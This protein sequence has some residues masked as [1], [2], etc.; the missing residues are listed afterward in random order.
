M[1]KT[2]LDLDIDNYNLQDL[3]KLFRISENFT[4]TDMREA[5]RIVLQ[6]HPDKSNLD[7]KYFLF[8][9]QAYKLIYGI[10]EFRQKIKRENTDYDTLDID[11]NKDNDIILKFLQNKS[12]KKDF[13][14]LFNE[15]F[16]KTK[17][18]D[19]FSKNGYNDW[20]TS[21]EDIED[22]TKLS[23]IEQEKK[24][25]L[26]KK[27]IKTLIPF[28]NISSIENEGYELDRSKPNDYSSSVFSTLS[29]NDL[30]K[31][32]QESIIPV[33][34]EDIQNIKKKSFSQLKNERDK[35]I[36]LPSLEQANKLL[37]EQKNNII[38]ESNLRAFN[39]IK[40]DEN[41]RRVNEKNL[42]FMRQLL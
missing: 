41:I 7:K 18:D 21:N 6:A 15:I 8:F 42:H 35:K 23:K 38:K 1:K 29:Y 34:K 40:E 26:K 28:Q 24:L 22:Y 16:E 4:E 32:H 3:I 33:T 14:K 12:V 31:A 37:T 10:F 30:K 9:S 5:K 20:L 27:N 13:N 2:D 11:N 39:L 25:E 36:S 19:E 17:I